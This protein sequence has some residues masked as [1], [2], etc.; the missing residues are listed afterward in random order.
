MTPLLFPN[1]LNLIRQLDPYS[2]GAEVGVCRGEFSRQILDSMPHL[3]TL[4]L[5][6]AWRHLGGAYEHDPENVDDGGHEDRFIRVQEMFAHDP[7][8]KIH[9]E[10]SVRAPFTC[11]IENLDWA[12]ID[13]DH[14]YGAVLSDLFAWSSLNPK[15]IMGHDYRSDS[16]TNK[17]Q[18]GVVEAVTMF[19]ASTQ[20]KLTKLTNEEWPSYWLEKP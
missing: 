8:V 19:C 12:Y 13:A 1:R 14:S 9:R 4:H 2:I 10:M 5:V 6:D 3:K 18:F 17:M 15:V 7:R 20:Y 11:G 16:V